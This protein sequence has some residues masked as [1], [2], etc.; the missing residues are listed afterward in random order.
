MS[1]GKDAVADAQSRCLG[2]QCHQ[3]SRLL[4]FFFFLKAQGEWKFFFFFERERTRQRWNGQW[5]KSTQPVDT[6]PALHVSKPAHRASPITSEVV[7]MAPWE[8]RPP[9]RSSRERATALAALHGNMTAH[10]RRQP[11][12]AVVRKCAGSLLAVAL[13]KPRRNS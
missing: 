2:G 12:R 7:G 6:Q 8:P 10:L 4:C 13:A 5:T 1:S 9:L 3:R 11:W